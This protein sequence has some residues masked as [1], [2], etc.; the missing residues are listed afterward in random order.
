MSSELSAS[1]ENALAALVSQGVGLVGLTSNNVTT[2]FTDETRELPSFACV[3]ADNE[4]NGKRSQTRKLTGSIQVESSSTDKY[5]AQLAQDRHSDLVECVIESID[6]VD[7]KSQLTGAAGGAF[8]VYSFELG[9]Q[10]RITDGIQ[11]IQTTIP[12]ECLC[13]YLGNNQQ[14][15]DS[16]GSIATDSEGNPATDSKNNLAI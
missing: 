10:S 7:I 11:Q 3:V 6:V 2:G 15:V 14:A 8:H 1:F 4:P 16:V 13:V 5:G 12:F 9:N